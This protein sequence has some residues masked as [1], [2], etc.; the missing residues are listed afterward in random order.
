MLNN[1][2]NDVTCG[3]LL[4]A[5]SCHEKYERTKNRRNSLKF[6]RHY[7]LNRTSNKNANV[8]NLSKKEHI[9]HSF[10]SISS[11]NQSKQS[12]GYKIR[13]E[14]KKS[15]R[16]AN[17][18]L[19]F[20]EQKWIGHGVKRFRQK[21]SCGKSSNS[22]QI[23]LVENRH[24]SKGKTELPRVVEQ[25][26]LQKETVLFVWVGSDKMEKIRWNVIRQINWNNK[27]AKMAPTSIQSEWNQNFAT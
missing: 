17:S 18:I 26:C 15:M 14:K 2:Y 12:V 25:K 11:H 13:Y 24:K 5:F 10:I 21:H 7:K 4:F 8:I 16:D 27:S 23:A 22:A 6:E 19:N 20:R 1:N 9:L 3:G